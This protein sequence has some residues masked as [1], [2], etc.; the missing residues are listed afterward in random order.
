MTFD[1]HLWPL[2]SWT[3]EGS[4]NMRWILHFEPI[5]QLDL[6]W[7][8][9]AWTYKARVPYCINKPSLVPIGLQLF[10]R[11]H[12]RIFSLSYNLTSDDIWPWY[13]TFDLINKWGFPC[14]IYDPPSLKSKHVDGRAECGKSILQVPD[15]GTQVL[16]NTTPFLRSSIVSFWITPAGSKE[17]K[18]H[19]F[20]QYWYTKNVLVFTNTGTF[21]YLGPEVYFFPKC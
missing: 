3:C 15:T 9:T 8:L 13:V 4:Y 6:W 20:R 2:T 16:A 12:F 14:C 18:Y 7:P 10:K 1:L 11:G 5:L 19:I 17:R 21:Q